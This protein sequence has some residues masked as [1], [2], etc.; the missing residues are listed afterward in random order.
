MAVKSTPVATPSETA[1]TS[2]QRLEQAQHEYT[3][4]AY[5]ASAAPLILDLARLSLGVAPGTPMTSEFWHWKHHANP[6]GASYGVY[7]WDDIRQ[8]AA[9]ARI[10]MR[11]SFRTGDERIL[12][13]VRA[14]DTATHPSYQRQGIFSNLTRHA[15]EELGQIGVDFIY[16][17]P[18]PK[19]LPGYLKMGWCVVACWPLYIRIL[20]PWRMFYRQLPLGRS[21][22]GYSFDDYFDADILNWCTFIHTYRD[23]LSRLIA[24][25]ETTRIQVGLRTVRNFDYLHWRY[26]QHPTIQYGVYAEKDASSGQL[27]GFAILRPNQRH[28]WQEVVLTDL[29]LTQPNKDIGKQLL[30]NLA[31]HIRA[32]YL[33]AHFAEHTLELHLLQRSAFLRLPRQG[34]IFTVR[35]LQPGLDKLIRPDQWDLSLGDLEIF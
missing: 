15:I 17:T 14:V 13:A 25:W 28:G 16:N 10:L 24:D 1:Q 30:H 34:M 4:Q 6:F 8:V 27:L 35:P 32:D 18:N 26:G 33:I 11:W 29:F 20:R 23:Q 31:R 5:Q 3:L 22:L 12:H 21:A 9:G 2:S 19:S 7:A